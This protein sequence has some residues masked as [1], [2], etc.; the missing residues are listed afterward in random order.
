MEMFVYIEDHRYGSDRVVWCDN[1]TDFSLQSWDLCLIDGVY[2][3][4]LG[5]HVAFEEQ[6]TDTMRAKAITVRIEKILTTRAL[7][8]I[9]AFVNQWFT[10]Y[11]Y[12]VPMFLGSQWDGLIKYEIRTKSKLADQSLQIFPTVWSMMQMTTEEERGKSLLLHGS[13]TP[14][15]KAKAF[16]AIKQCKVTSVLATYSQIFHDRAALKSITLHDQHAWRYKNQKDPRYYLPTVVDQLAQNAGA[17]VT[18]TGHHLPE[19]FA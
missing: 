6:Y 15:Q 17:T 13:L 14:V 11:K 9:H 5:K 16:W 12:V 18:K 8:R 7:K 3:L 1:A 10:T 4:C 19:K 2:G